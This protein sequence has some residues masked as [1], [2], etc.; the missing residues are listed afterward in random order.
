M[1]TRRNCIGL[2]IVLWSGENPAAEKPSLKG[3]IGIG[4]VF[5]IGKELS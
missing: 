5:F 3:T 4:T 1:L 2:L